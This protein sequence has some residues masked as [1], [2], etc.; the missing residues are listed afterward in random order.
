M[1]TMHILK[2]ADI[3]YYCQLKWFSAHCSVTISWLRVRSRSIFLFLFRL[4][5][6]PHRSAVLCLVCSRSRFARLLHSF[7]AWILL[8]LT[9][10]RCQAMNTYAYTYSMCL[11]ISVNLSGML[12]YIEKY[13]WNSFSDTGY[14]G[15]FFGFSTHE[16]LNFNSMASK[17]NISLLSLSFILP[18]FSICIAHLN[19]AKQNKTK[20]K[21][22]SSSLS[23]RNDLTTMCD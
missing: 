4:I 17:T 21:K 12:L 2:T 22:L 5:S 3:H 14:T 20:H 18:T 16:H 19:K 13:M 6:Y 9:D 23:L 1:Y 7:G 15:I 11:C 8:V 10:Y